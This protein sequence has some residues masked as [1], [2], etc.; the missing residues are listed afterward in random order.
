MQRYWKEKA[1]SY[2]A[3]M[4]WQHVKQARD[5]FLVFPTLNGGYRQGAM[6]RLR[7]SFG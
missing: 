2:Q 4:K 6:R 1:Y 5:L 7:L 3:R